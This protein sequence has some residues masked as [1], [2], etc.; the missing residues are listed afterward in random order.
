MSRPIVIGTRLGRGESIG[1]DEISVAG[2]SPPIA[3][4]R[5]QSATVVIASDRARKTHAPEA[6]IITAAIITRR[7]RLN[8]RDSKLPAVI[9]PATFIS[10]IRALRIPAAPSEMFRRVTS[11]I[12]KS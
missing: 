4:N 3:E 11:R 10:V 6:A 5:A 2:M 8:P 7:P 1:A 12:G 9:L